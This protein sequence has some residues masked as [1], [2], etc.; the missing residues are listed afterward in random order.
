MTLPKQMNFSEK[1][2]GG[3]R[4]NF[5]CQIFCADFEPLNRA[6]S[7]KKQ[8]GGFLVKGRLKLFRKL[9]RFR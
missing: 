4:G 1:F 5:Q 3:G 6:F 8:V 9:V 2:Q 7:E